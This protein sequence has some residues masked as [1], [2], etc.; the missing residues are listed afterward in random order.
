MGTKGSKNTPITAR[1]S[2][3]LFNKKKGVQEPLLSVGP[4]GVSGN[5]QTRD[6]SSPSK[7]K[8]YSMKASPFKQNK[9]GIN[10][11]TKEQTGST[12]EK[13]D[14]IK[15][16]VYDTGKSLKGLSQEQLDWRTNE[17]KKLGGIDQYH[18]KYGSKTKGKKTGSQVGTGTFKTDKE[19]PGKIT[20]SNEFTANKTRDKG[21]AQTAL[22]RRNVIRSG[23]VGARTEKAAQRKTDRGLRRSGAIDPSTIK[24]DK[25]GKVIEGSGKKYNKR[26]QRL[27]RNAT[28]DAT[29]LKISQNV[30]KGAKNQSDQNIGPRSNKDV[31]NAERDMS[32]SDVGGKAAQDEVIK[33]S[34]VSSSKPINFSALANTDNNSDASNFFKKKT[35][36]KKK[37]FK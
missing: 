22:D 16:D 26:D 28:Q 37:Y 1:V 30:V 35:P 36:I 2:T 18:A 24:K 21:D 12:F 11:L 34:G 4:A 33:A 20:E 25:D 8:G 15:E 23:K 14:E 9:V 32:L 19:I 27:A 17:I 29:N 5:N 6:I 31:L 7:M 10:V 3:G 13:G